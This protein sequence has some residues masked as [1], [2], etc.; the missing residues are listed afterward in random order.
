MPS[1]SLSVNLLAPHLTP[2]N[3]DA[4]LEAATQKTTREIEQLLAECFPRSETLALVQALPP[5]PPLPQDQRPP[6]PT[7]TCAPD[8]IRAASTLAARQVAAAPR[9]NVTPVAPE[10]FLV[11][12][13]IGRSAPRRGS[14]RDRG[15]R[16]GRRRRAGA[17]TAMQAQS[18]FPPTPKQEGPVSHA[19]PLQRRRG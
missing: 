6:E 4:L 12:F 19:A 11:Q 15:R 14:P 9:R 16:P 13:T 2:E 7:E 3:A 18:T 5:S 1:Y 10:R 17:V 8:G